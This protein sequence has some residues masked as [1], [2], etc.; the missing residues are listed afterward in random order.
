MVAVTPEPGREKPSPA[1]R[2]DGHATWA[3]TESWSRA[4][5]CQWCPAPPLRGDS[6]GQTEVTLPFSLKISLLTFQDGV[7]FT[8]TF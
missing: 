8:E 4:A 7:R 6:A 5:A 2:Q 3:Q 1:G